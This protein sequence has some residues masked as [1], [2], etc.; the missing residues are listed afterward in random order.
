[1]PD[2][3]QPAYEPRGGAKGWARG[4]GTGYPDV[5]PQYGKL[6]FKVDVITP[7]GEGAL[8]LA[9][10]KLKVELGA[11]GYFRPERKRPIPE[12]VRCVGLITSETGVVYRDFSRG[13]GNRG[14]K[15]YFYD[16][17]VEG[18][19]AIESIVTAVQWFNQNTSDVE[20]LVIARG[21]GSLEQLQPFNSIEVAKAIYGSRIPVMTAIGH[22]T[23]VT[24]ADLVADVRA[25]VPMDAGKR[26]GAA[27]EKAEER[28]GA[29]EHNISAA[30][31]SRCRD[32][33]SRLAHYSESL[34][35][36]Y[37]KQLSQNRQI[38]AAHRQSLL[39]CFRD[40]FAKVQT[41]EQTFNY[42]FQRFANALSRR[43]RGIASFER[44]LGRAA[45]RPAARL[46]SRLA[47]LEADFVDSGTRFDRYL[48]SLQDDLSDSDLQISQRGARW[49]RALGKR[50]ADREAMLA[51]HDP[52]HK[53]KQGYS[54]VK[55]KSGNVLRSTRTDA[56]S[57][58]INV[59]LY[60]GRLGAKVENIS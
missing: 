22:E 8:R 56:V 32:F 24:I 41:V 53:L 31:R 28:I 5:Y 16:A 33:S 15:L 1:M 14:I 39:R 4:Q 38:I 54:I 60:D 36:S 9:F 47:D 49:Y 42:N 20:A 6:T 17:R 27:W 18:A 48:H 50:L 35:S 55:D 45:D 3:A 21:G 40:I 52:R 12:Y 11:Q 19:N 59:E 2:L 23:D 43:R 10:E 25:S 46:A 44:A 51:A 7:V 37:A 30:F 13:L 26:L 58:I 57:D 29:I 34:V